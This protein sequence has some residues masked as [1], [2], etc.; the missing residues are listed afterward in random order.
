[1]SND[2]PINKKNSDFSLEDLLLLFWKHRMMIIII[3][4]F[5]II[6]S[7]FYSLV[8]D[9]IYEVNCTIRPAQPSE[10]VTLLES[11]F[12]TQFSFVSGK[13]ELPVA[14]EITSYLYSNPFLQKY[15]EKY[16]DKENSIFDDKLLKI[17]NSDLDPKVKEERMYNGAMKILKDDIIKIYDD[18][19]IMT[20]T[21]RLK[22]KYLAKEF[23]AELTEDLK[24]Y[25]QNKNKSIL[26]S[27]ITFY[28][29]VLKS[30]TDP[31]IILVLQNTINK[32]LE[33]SC[34]IST[35]IFQVVEDPVIPS[36]RFWPKRSAIV[37]ASTLF[38]FVFSFFFV[39][40]YSYL[41]DLF[42]RIKLKVKKS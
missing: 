19:F 15:Y 23:L 10:E 5:F 1:M 35:N 24:N 3:N 36:K 34:L 38:G 4:L 30:T 41:F 28:E 39:I 18:G 20:I 25:I 21:I 16:K 37:I 6:F 12:F 13:M 8:T 11:S 22:D 17:K 26:Q 32:K 7:I 27:Q 42:K 29:E 40:V 14:K 9:E 31:N 33:K 2:N